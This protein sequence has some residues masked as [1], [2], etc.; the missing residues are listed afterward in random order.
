DYFF[1]FFGILLAGCVPV[2][3]YPPIRL[4]QIEDHLRRH[5]AILNNAGVSI[6]ITLPEARPIAWILKSQVMSLQRVM[7]TQEL[8]SA[9]GLRSRPPINASDTA[10]LQYT[11]GS[12]GT[13]KGVVLTHDNLLFIAGR[14]S[15]MRR[16]ARTDR[17]YAVLP[18]SHVF[19]LASVL[20]GTLYQGGRLDLIPRF[21]AEAAARA[22]AADGITVFQG[23]PQMYARL[24]AFAESR[25]N[26]LAP[27]L[28][29]ISSGG[30]PLDPGIKARIEALW[31]LPLHNG[32]GL[33]ETSPTATTTVIERPVDDESVGPPLPDVGL[34]IVGPDGR[35]L[36]P[37]EVGEIEIRGRLVMKGYYRAPEATAAAM[38]PD[39]FFKSGDLGRIDARG[40]LYVVGRVR[41]LIIRSG[42]NVY[43][44]EVEGVLSAHPDIAVAAVIGRKAGDGNEEVVAFLQ[45]K[46]GRCIDPEAMRAYA[47]ARLAPYKRP[48]EYRVMAELPAAATGKLLKHK[49]K[50]FL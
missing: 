31:G 29:Y 33:T 1:S 4:S 48:S 41:E 9:E 22:F 45:P 37:G 50:D 43:P 24:A 27:T 46:P 5:A 25:G 49:L 28:R 8:L 20:N 36:P 47:A 14:S 44:P 18:V 42:F 19:G 10:F 21:E 26:F 34:R 23:V 7:S 17:V 11:S 39:G 12:T 15:E 38:R 35:A 32:Y 40:H 2:P 16:L 3:L 30:A 6:L 13:P